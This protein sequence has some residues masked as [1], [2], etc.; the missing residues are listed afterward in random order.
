VQTGLL[1]DFR[2]TLNPDYT[3]RVRWLKVLSGLRGSGTVV[4]LSYSGNK[5]QGLT[6]GTILD[7]VDGA[8]GD[9]KT[10]KGRIERVRS[11]S[12]CYGAAQDDALTDIANGPYDDDGR[13]LLS[14]VGNALRKHANNMTMIDDSFEDAI[15]KLRQIAELCGSQSRPGGLFD[16][17][18]GF[19]GAD[20]TFSA[21]L[22][23][24]QFLKAVVKFEGTSEID[25][26]NRLGETPLLVAC[27]CGQ[28]LAVRYLLHLGANPRLAD[29]A[30]ITPLHW[31]S[32]FEDGEMRG[33]SQLLSDAGAVVDA[34]TTSV[35]DLPEHC[36]NFQPG[37]TP[38]H[39]AVGMRSLAAVKTLLSFGANP[40]SEAELSFAF[41]GY[42]LTPLHFA[43]C[44]HFHEIVEELLRVPGTS[45]NV[46]FR[47][48][49]EVGKKASAVSIVHL[50]SVRFV[51]PS[52]M[53]PFA[54]WVVH[55]KHYEEALEKTLKAISS[56]FPEKNVLMLQRHSLSVTFLPPEDPY[57]LRALKRL[58]FC[59]KKL[60]PEELGLE[61]ESVP[62]QGENW[63]IELWMRGAVN[64]SNFKKSSPTM[65]NL[66]LTG[67][68]NSEEKPS[69]AFVYEI[70]EHCATRDMEGP[71]GSL[72][73]HL[74]LQ[75]ALAQK[76][77]PFFFWLA[78]GHDA[79]AVMNLFWDMFSKEG[80]E[81][82]DAAAKV[83][84]PLLLF[85]SR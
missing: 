81:G 67:L 39:Y 58:E 6:K 7:I 69:P 45:S 55:G 2:S 82:E 54:H 35:L 10:V 73:G 1:G 68:N 8:S 72:L 65:M 30:G 80:G 34:V 76:L 62:H 9:G 49:D 63:G 71:L 4:R 14:G 70:I 33:I 36:L 13:L 53:A 83:A 22:K 61:A 48:I 15:S 59:P 29:N 50:V 85:V 77:I 79:V 31:L 12:F 57:I 46:L 25:K 60:S 52:V 41:H 78:A 75:L 5:R 27:R 11:R 17:A 32:L 24:V 44:L 56:V 37:C 74:K 26:P 19:V 3:E 40:F 38:L 23:V 43:V 42:R 21:Q 20:S 64:G 51:M 66:A 18:A 84:T 47:R 28:S 16:V